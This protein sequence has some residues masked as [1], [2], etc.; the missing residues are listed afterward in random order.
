MD[1]LTQFALGAGIGAVVLGPRIGPRKAA[2]TGGLLGTLPDLD[3]LLPFDDPIDAFILHR[4]AS[5][6]FLVHALATPL[7]GEALLRLFKGLRDHRVRTYLAVFLVFATH[8][9]LDA[10]TIYGTRIFWPIFSDPVGTGSIF[11]IDPIYSLPLLLVMIWALCLGGWSS[12][13]GSALGAALLFTTAYLGAGL[14]AQRLVQDRAEDLLAGAGISAERLLA[15]PTPFNTLFWK[16]IAID[17]GRY[18]NLYLPLFGSHT[19]A[20]AFVHPR[21]T[22]QLACLGDSDA[23][24]KLA[25]FSDGYFRIDRRGS[26]ILVSDLR[27]GL[28][29]NYV[30]SFAIAEVTSQGVRAMAPQRRRTERSAEGD[31]GWLLANLAGDAMLRPIEAPAV[32]SLRDPLRVARAGERTAS[33]S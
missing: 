13:F 29:P 11:I 30:F 2:V 21:G 22:E 14:I 10:L 1:S 12:R 25:K 15:I 7:F 28:T 24:A 5:H 31:L 18:I 17:G 19:M 32:A 33:C 26:E 6:A 27:M 8:A 9:L 23:L 4:G 20:T 16:V 3:I